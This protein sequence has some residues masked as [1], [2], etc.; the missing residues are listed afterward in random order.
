MKRILAILLTLPLALTAC[1]QTDEPEPAPTTIAAPTTTETPKGEIGK[2]FAFTEQIDPTAPASSGT[3]MIDELYVG[4]AAACKGAIT[5]YGQRQ[6]ADYL[7]IVT[8]VDLESHSTDMS[9][10]L[11]G[12]KFL[13]GKRVLADGEADHSYLL[14]DIEDG[15]FD[16]HEGMKANEERVFYG[17]FEIPE[18]ADKIEL[19]GRTFNMSDVEKRDS[20]PPSTNPAPGQR[21][22]AP[23]AP[24]VVECLEGTPG[25]ALMS[26]GSIQNSD[27]CFQQLGG[28]AYLE[29]E[30]R[31]CVGPASECGYGYDEN[32]NPNPTSGEIQTYHG[33]E[34]GYITDPELCAAVRKKIEG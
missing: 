26:D 34:D 18:G 13:Q 30:G 25:P 32:G 27:Y 23:E 5:E 24:H 7:H 17:A 12:P 6:T 11:S 2:P 3:M 16:Y 10:V 22:E 19:H 28:E 20:T 4:P 31:Q 21:A 1:S 14:C 29:E 15:I 33:C 9:F 8:T